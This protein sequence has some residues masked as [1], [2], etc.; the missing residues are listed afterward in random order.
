MTYGTEVD[1]IQE[2]ATHIVL[3]SYHYEEGERTGKIQLINK[4][5][6][7]IEKEMHTTGTLDVSVLNE[8]IYAANGSD[9]SCYKD[10]SLL[11]KV[12]TTHLNTYISTNSAILEYLC[13]SDTGGNITFYDM[14]LKVLG[15]QNLFKDAIWVN[16]IMDSK[17]YA[18]SEDG[19]L[20]MYDTETGQSTR[21]LKRA[22]GII[23]IM[24]EDGMMYISAYDD[25]VEGLDLRSGKIE[26]VAD[27]TGSLWRMRRSGDFIHTASMYDGYKLFDREFNMICS[28]K[29]DSICYGLLVSNNGVL[30]SS[31]YDK[32]IFVSQRM[33]KRSLS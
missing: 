23:D 9:V 29:T 25:R 10:E 2:N 24:N 11:K 8:R 15:A 5:T 17:V 6:K 32:S 28:H 27:N 22:S 1:S 26:K 14:S 30:W 20:C 16:S 33:N 7:N 4:A 18:G 21:I 13:I 31:F 12:S 19:S 3:G